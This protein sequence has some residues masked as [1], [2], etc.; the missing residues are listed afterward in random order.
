MAVGKAFT[1]VDMRMWYFLDSDSAVTDDGLT[2][3]ETAIADGEVAHYYGNFSYTAG[4][5]YIT[6]TGGTMTGADL[7]IDGVR[8]YTVSGINA[9]A[10]RIYDY[11]VSG[12]DAAGKAMIKYVFSGADTLTGSNAADIIKGYGG[13][14]RITG[15]GGNDK[16]DGGTGNDTI[17][18]GAG[19]AVNGA[20]GND[21]LKLAIDLDLTSLPNTR[22]KNIET[23]DMRGGGAAG[24]DLTLS[25]TDVLALSASTNTLKILGDANDRINIDT[26]DLGTPTRQGSFDR[27]TFSTPGGTAVLLIES[28]INNV[29]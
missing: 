15:K 26:P 22:I 4:S 1:A 18:W 27:Y 23:I 14:D 13:N 7:F 8:Q 17:T 21:R 29:F 12:S 2:V 16:V 6:I 25:L 9:D 10:T 19:D 20:A 24:D 28:D 3:T 5:P 11:L